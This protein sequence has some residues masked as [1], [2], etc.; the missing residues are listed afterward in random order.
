VTSVGGFFMELISLFKQ[1]LTVERQYS[2]KT[3]TAYLEDIDAFQKF[4]TDTGD[5]TDLL[6]VDRF[7]VNVYMSYLFDRHLARTSISRKVSALRSFY[8][9]LVKNDLVDKNPFELVQ[10]KKQSDKL[11]HFFYEK[12]MNML[13]EAVYQAEGAQKLRNI[14]I[15]EVLYGTGMRV[16]ECAALQWSDIDFSMQTILVLGKGNKERYVPFGRY[17]KEALQNYRK[18]EWEPFLSKY[19]QT[20]NFVFINHYAKPITTTGIEYI[21]NQVIT[22]SSLNGKIHPHMLRHS[23]ATALLNNGADLR[24]VQELLGHSSLSTT[25]I[26]THVTKEK[27]Q[28]SYRKYFPRSTDA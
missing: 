23:F 4:L 20:H 9:F 22:A 16:S 6:L 26:Y 28:E 1:Y 7:D 17:A 3:V 19:K 25:Q 5:K 18:N 11:P 13:F 24:T 15:L 8:R 27:L 21:L 10:L 12:E 2:E 14:A